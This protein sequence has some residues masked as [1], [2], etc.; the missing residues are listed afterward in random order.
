MQLGTI[1]GEVSVRSEPDEFLTHT[2]LLTLA[3]LLLSSLA[4]SQQNLGEPDVPDQFS[5]DMKTAA[6][7]RPELMAESIPA[8]G[9]YAT[10][11]LVFDRL[12]NQAHGPSGV[13]FGWQLRIV[14]ND[15][16]N[17]YASPDGSVYV[18]SGLSRLAGAST[19][20]WA[21]ILSH[22]IAHVIRRDWGRRYLY[23][24]SLEGGG[25]AAIV[26]GD[27]GLPSGS[28]TDA[29][30]ASQ[31]LGRFCRQLEIEADREGL[32]LM[33]RAGY[34]PDFVPALHHLLHAQ[35]SGTTTT[36]LYSMHPCWEER[37]RELNGAYVAASIEFDHRWREWYASPGGNPPV[38]V[39]ADEPRVRK[40]G[41]KGWEIQI[42][43]RC[44]NL[45]G[46][47]EVV[48]RADSK[49]RTQEPLRRLPEGTGSDG[50]LR[51]L[52][53]CTSP[54]T[55]ITFT[56]AEPSGGQKPSTHWTDVYVLDAWGTVLAR[57]DV[58][59]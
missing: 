8:S 52:T 7:L 57:A 28:W 34:H 30:K 32:M 43:M 44:Q 49:P 17:A 25:G 31:D 12:L 2:I 29:Q 23:Q 13:K 40:T 15:E 56:L 46:A 39:F 20:L 1:S 41:S 19:G 59:K 10:G 21:A 6:R 26:L 24:K 4:A 22:E 55:T 11:R 38:V 16:F 14:E 58:P 9:R 18:E 50:E 51:Q 37:D 5:E 42:P 47:V 36:T 53:G 48:V 3:C 33:A 35:G 45:A 27:P 54:R